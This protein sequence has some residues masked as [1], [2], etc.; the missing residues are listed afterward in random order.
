MRHRNFEVPEDL[1]G[2]FAKAMGDH[3]LENVI[4]GVN[5]DGDIIV[6]VDYEPEQKE[7]I[8]KISD[9]IDEYNDS[10]DEDEE[11]QEDDDD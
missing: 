4:E 3:D 6:T 11:E 7:I 1:I 10:E 9:T 8:N 2:Q 5:E